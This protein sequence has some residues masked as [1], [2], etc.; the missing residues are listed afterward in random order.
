LTRGAEAG[1]LIRYKT[2]FFGRVKLILFGPC[3][4][5]GWGLRGQK[6]KVAD[7]DKSLLK[8]VVSGEINNQLRKKN[9]ESE[10]NS[11]GG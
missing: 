10:P 8:K 6:Q 3:P 5:P 2:L 9:G 1:I 7:L 4:A 11:S